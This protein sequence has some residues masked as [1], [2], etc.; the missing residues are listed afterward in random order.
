MDNNVWIRLTFITASQLEGQNELVE[1]LR[2]ICRVQTPKIWLPAF[3]SGFEFFADLYINVTLE[4]FIKNVV[5]TGMAWDGTKVVLAKIWKA[6]VGFMERNDSADLQH[7]QLYFD[8]A[9]IKI[10]LLDNYGFLRRMYLS[11]PHHFYVLKMKG[12]TD[13]SLIELPFVESID[14]ETGGFSMNEPDFESTEK[15]FWWRI[16]YLNGCNWCYYKPS[17]EEF[18]CSSGWE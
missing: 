15:D 3:C 14:E 2:G 18:Q 4:D 10:N 8:D 17:T 12:I 11:L 7:L 5:L 9:V 1:E 16:E 6:F 13:I